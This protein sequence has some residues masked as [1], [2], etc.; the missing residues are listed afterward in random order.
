MNNDLTEAEEK[1][2]RQLDDYALNQ[3]ILD[4]AKRFKASQFSNIDDFE[5]F[6]AQYNTQNTTV[7]KL[8]WITPLLRIASVVVIAFGIYFSFFF[9]NNVYVQ[10]LASQ[11]TT[12]ELPDQSQVVLNAMSSI[13][14]SEK[15][16]KDSRALKLDGEAY[17]KVAKGKTFD[18]ITSQGKVTV[19][20]TA[21]NV[22]QR[23]NYFEV[24]CFEGVVK[25]TSDTI[26]RQLIAGDTYSM[27][28]G[29]FTSDKINAVVPEWTNNNS[30]FNAMPIKEVV[31]E[32]ERQYNIQVRFKDVNT[33]R[34]FTGGFTH[35]NL[36]NALIS[37]TQ[38]MNMTYEL[39]SSNQVIINGQKR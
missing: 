25:V 23:D 14:Y 35:N 17:F 12:I 15:N 34:L 26:T 38:P 31:A 30:I 11:K 29:K 9:N 24:Q 32:L 33:K 20:G 13:D 6:K 3:E 28:E 10:T 39:K 36:N 16:W 5:T 8:N 21:F 37:I 7:K 18:V 19:V 2:F 4:T 1:V 22:K 27:F